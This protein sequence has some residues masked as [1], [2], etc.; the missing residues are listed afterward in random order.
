MAT[1]ATPHWEAVT[2]EARELLAILGQLPFLRPFY[3]AGGTAL[4]LRL[5]HRISQDLDLFA[6]VET[7]DDDLRRS[8]V[9]ELRKDHSVNLL[10][11]SVLGLVLKVNEQPVSFFSYG[12]PLL[13][14][15]DLVSGIQVAG[16][17]DIGL[18]KLDAIAGRGMRKDFYDLYFIA[19]H[20]SLDELFARSSDKYPQSHDFGMRVLSALVDFDIADRQDEPTLLLPVEWEQV[21]TFFVTQARRLGQKWFGPRGEQSLAKKS[22]A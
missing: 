19:S 17:L 14:A 16:I 2:P 8:I 6:N 15:T 13:A 22:Q 7:L 18:M 12:Y 5:S 10:Q 21:K 1:L 11:D 9:E 4:A 20:I 3:L